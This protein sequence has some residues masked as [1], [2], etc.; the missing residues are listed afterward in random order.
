MPSKITE[1]REERAK[2][3]TDARSLIDKAESEGRDLTDE[4]QGRYDEM[5]S[6]ARKLDVRAKRQEEL[7][8]LE[9]SRAAEDA[10]NRG[11]NP[12]GGVEN[13][14][15]S[16]SELQMAGFRSILAFGNDA[17]DHDEAGVRSFQEYSSRER[18]NLSLGGGGASGGYLVLPEELY[19][20]LIR[21]LNNEVFIRDLA[22][23]QSM[24]NAV[25]LGVPTLEQDPDDFEFTEEL[26]T[27]SEDSATRFGKRNFEPNPVAKRARIS[28]TLLQ[29]STMPVEQILRDRLNYKMGVTLEKAYM[30]GNGNRRPLGLFVTHEDGI[31][32]DRNIATG[33]TGTAITFDGLINAK[34]ALTAA[35]RRDASWIF[36]RDAVSMVSKLKDNENRYVWR[37]SEREGDPDL[38]LGHAYRESEYA[39]NTFTTGLIV[40]LLGNLRYYWIVDVSTVAI[41]RLT[42]LYAETNQIGLILRMETDGMPVREK[43]FARVT[44]G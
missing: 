31:T 17:R 39:P 37:V 35:Y 20:G 25:S 7:Q 22:T 44:L 33:N 32:S 29:R 10:G 36:H 42:E 30:L 2:L 34:Y 12:G 14:E 3:I 15:R 27:G 4:E 18:R 1:L 43:A 21:D 28:E 16:Q 26:G 24:P 11:L 19:S 40:G 8:E 5:L 13:E 9:R 41:R 23:V 38:L 6:D